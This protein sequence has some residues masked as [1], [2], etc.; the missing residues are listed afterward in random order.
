MGSFWSNYT[1]DKS[2]DGG[3][4]YIYLPY[5]MN[6]DQI[7][8]SEAEARTIVILSRILERCGIGPVTDAPVTLEALK[9]ARIVNGEVTCS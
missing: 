5:I 3:N 9:V 1:I 4:L 8:D 7:T 2:L 6:Y